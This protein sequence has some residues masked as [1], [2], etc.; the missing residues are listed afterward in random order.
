[1]SM[2]LIKKLRNEL[3][4]GFMDCKKALEEA[5]NDYDKA[6]DILRQKGAIKAEKK[7]DRD[8]SEGFVCVAFK[9]NTA[10]IIELNCETDFVSR[11][12]LFTDLC[13]NILSKF[14]DYKNDNLSQFDEVVKT[15]IQDVVMKIGENVK[16]GKKIKFTSSPNT[17]LTS[18][19]HNMSSGH[20]NMGRVV[21]VLNY[22]SKSNSSE[23][24]DLARKIC[25]HIT[26]TN[27]IGIQESDISQEVVE[28]E[29]NI[30]VAQIEEMGKPKE[31]AEK[32]AQGKMKKFLSEKLLPEQ[33]F[34]IDGKLT[35]KE[36]ISNFN[37]N[38]S[39]DFELVKFVTVKLGI[40]E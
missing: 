22:Q 28:K 35:V 2:D 13:S 25:M 31:M 9:D 21:T 19:I 17:N 6:V 23:A 27:P 20:N 10:N 4:A 7:A 36:Y 29:K 40:N 39:D 30:F 37:K 38:N 1:M 8:A 18:Y 16:L 34:V 32:I 14:S 5:N 15:D 12:L 24:V 3:S 26:A 33:I 11:N